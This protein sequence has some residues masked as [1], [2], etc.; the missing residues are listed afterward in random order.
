MPY[1]VAQGR[2]P[3]RRAPWEEGTEDVRSDDRRAP[4]RSPHVPHRV[5]RPRRSV[6]YIFG[7]AGGAASW[8]CPSYP[9]FPCILATPPSSGLDGLPLALVAVCYLLSSCTYLRRWLPLCYRFSVSAKPRTRDQDVGF[10]IDLRLHWYRSHFIAFEPKIDMLALAPFEQADI[11]LAQE[12]WLSQSRI[13]SVTNQLRGSWNVAYGEPCRMQPTTRHVKAG[14]LAP[15]QYRAECSG[16]LAMTRA[17]C[18]CIP[19]VM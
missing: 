14:S 15:Q 10:A 16:V 17:P 18:I 19:I 1:E 11:V 6:L 12:T 2:A 13:C 7:R 8:T 4:E 5:D 9:G 3:P